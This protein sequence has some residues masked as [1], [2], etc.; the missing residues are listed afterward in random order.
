MLDAQVAEWQPT[1]LVVGLPLNMDGTESDMSAN[2]PAVR[3]P[4]TRSL[5]NS[6]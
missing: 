3:R 2:D 4:A 5:W 1:L 6:H